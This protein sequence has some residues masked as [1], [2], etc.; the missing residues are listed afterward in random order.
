MIL[1]S[2]AALA[3]P[4]PC[5]TPMFLPTFEPR[6]PIPDAPPRPPDEKAERDAY[7]SYPHSLFST[8]FIVKWG[9]TGGVTLAEA[10]MLL[11]AMEVGWAVEIG[12]MGH[13]APEGTDEYLFNIYIGDT[14]NNTPDGYGAG[15]Y[16]NRDADGMP[17]IVIARQSVYYEEYVVEAAVHEFY[18]ALQDRTGRYTYTG[19]S[20]WYWEATAEWAGGEVLPDNPTYAQ[21]LYGYIF[22]P[23]L[24]VNF[25]DY[26]D[27]W[28]LQE[29]HQYGAFIFPRFLT[30][31][32]ATRALVVDSWIVPGDSNDPME[33]LAAGLAAEGLSMPD[34][35]AEFAAHNAVWDYADGVLY[36]QTV[37]EAESYWS[38]IYIADS[39]GRDGTDGWN[40]PASALLPGPFSYN[41]VTSPKPESGG[42]TF[43]FEG[44]AEGD[45]GAAADWRVI[46]VRE[47]LGGP[48]YLPMTLVDGA[49]E[50][51]VEDA[52]GDGNYA[53]VIVSAGSEG[54]EGEVFGYRFSVVPDV[55]PGA[56]TSDDTDEAPEAT[57]CGCASGRGASGLAALIALAWL[58]PRRRRR[59]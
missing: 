53:M 14:G 12:E 31:H 48:E 30:E 55:P 50:L 21:F 49:G 52:G 4:F 8:N 19:D 38:D 36:L 27:T 17:M 58:G 41:V 7:G 9:N 6:P 46:V 47:R 18:H 16:Y 51:Y 57:G 35:F 11:D 45:R 3:A 25:F 39:V 22:L 20:A 29:Y 37:G 26:P 2:L 23:Y 28:A 42:L 32:V 56:G 40:E 43:A 59:G 10:Q 1:A 5:G 13:P 15:G 54:R 33:V 24:P 44:G 34:V